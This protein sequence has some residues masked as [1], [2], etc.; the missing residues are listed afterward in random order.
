MM[1][2]DDDE[3]FA[4]LIVRIIIW[5]ICR[6]NDATLAGES[7][8]ATYFDV[9]VQR[10]ESVTGKKFNDRVSYEQAIAT[11]CVG[12]GCVRIAKTRCKFGCFRILTVV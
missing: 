4:I 8:T 11:A 2:I 12:D 1:M 3:P 10:L 7:S 5:I 6:M 9:V